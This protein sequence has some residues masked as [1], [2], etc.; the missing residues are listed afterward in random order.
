ML[1]LKPAILVFAVL[2]FA[3]LGLLPAADLQR[4]A[5][6][7]GT[8]AVS[9]ETPGDWSTWIVTQEGR[10]PIILSAPHGGQS[11]ITGVPPRT[12]E[13]LA[14]G[15][16]GFVTSRD[17]GTQELTLALAAALE[18]RMG[19]KPYYVAAKFHRRFVDANRPAAIAYEHAGAKPAYEA[20]H[21]TLDRYC[22]E[23]RAR[24][25][26]GLL[27]DIHGQ[28]AAQDTVFR[29]TQNGRTVA[30][31]VKRFGEQAQNGP[32]S[33]F[34]LMAAR[35]FKVFAEENGRERAGFTGGYI[36]SHYGGHQA[37]GIDALQLEFG[38]DY[39]AKDKI[40]ATAGKLAEA[41]LAFARL[42]LPEQPV[43]N[44]SHRD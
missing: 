36:V 24:F 9:G 16:K 21:H 7:V 1:R 5:E 33:F 23:V 2:A 43:G 12:G 31:L 38:G 32:E 27:L 20:Y 6:R 14:K 11:E 15:P 26:R 28:S 35:G 39:R 19:A 22:R 13:G 44:A 37:T 8:P 30:S 17:F 18:A 40:E 25:G 4:E 10:L 41:I 3:S 42:Y 34:G 29:G